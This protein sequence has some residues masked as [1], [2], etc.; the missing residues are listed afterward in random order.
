MTQS[1]T[2]PSTDRSPRDP[3]AAFAA[4][5]SPR[6]VA[7]IGA[8]ERAGSVGRTVFWN[9]IRN[10]FGGTVY[11]VNPQR[12]SVLGVRSYPS[13]ADLPEVPDLVVIVTPASSVPT[14]MSQCADL[15]VKAA[16][17]L[18]AG[19]RETGP[20]GVELERQTL[21]HARR[22]RM[23]VLGPNCLGLMN[24]HSGLNATFANSLA[25]PG[26]VAFI[27]QS[28]ALC[29]AVLDWSFKEHVGFSV[30]A[31]LG[32]MLDVGWGDL[33]DHLGED[34]NTKSIVIYM[35]SIGDARSFLSAAREVALRKPIIVIKAGRTD[36]AA[37]AAASHTGAMTGSDDVLDAAFK[38]V[39]VLRVDRISD[40]FY[41]AEVLSKQPRPKGPRLAIITNAGGPGVLA[42]DALVSSGGELAPVSE[43][44]LTQLNAILP[45]AWSHNNPI[46]LLGDA[47]AKRYLDAIEIVNRD[48]DSDGTLVILTPQDMTDPTATAKA[49]RDGLN[50]PD[51]PVLASWM[52]GPAVA[53][54][55]TILGRAGIPTFPY[56]DTAAKTFCAMW[57]YSYNLKG[58]YETPSITD[59]AHDPAP[60]H[61]VTAI[62]QQARKDNRTLLTEVESKEILAAYDLP[63][64]QTFV[65]TDAD[66]AVA[67]AEKIGYPVV[68]KLYSQTVTHKTDVGGVELNIRSE[69]GVRRAF[70]NIRTSVTAKVGAAAFDGVAVQRMISREGYEIIVGSSIDSQFGPVI[71]F[72]AGGQLVEIFR[73]SA[74]GLPPLNSTLA[75]RMM[76]Q[77]RIHEA[78]KGVRG[79]PPVD[80]VALERFLVRF[81]QLVLEHPRIK[82]IDINPLLASPELIIAL[83]ARVILHDASVPD[84]Q[85]PRP[86]IRPY[87]S[88]Y[89]TPCKLKDGSD[90]LIRPIRPED[91][92]LL[93]TFHSTL[94]E[95]T[96]Y[97]R[98]FHPMSL[99]T[100]VEHE[101]LS[102]I[103]FNDYD[104]ELAL[105]ALR[106]GPRGQEIVAVGRLIKLR[107]TTDAEFGLIVSD[108]CQRQ[109]L[110]SELLRQLLQVARD[111]KIDRVLADILPDNYE[112]ET[113]VKKLGFS[114]SRGSGVREAVIDLRQTPASV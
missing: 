17:V 111:E 82:S 26:S 4:L 67:L 91:E 96:V 36:A 101:R 100:R 70:D 28:G 109:G 19:F 72:G 95:R 16:I 25:K 79:R 64:V 34:P 73:D 89:V 20:A 27:S 104:R 32:S 47:D 51:R 75:R 11:P 24:P 12:P 18:S 41:M 97:F 40:L 69:Q 39:G 86:A 76:E 87:P 15:G 106:T 6:S 113:L 68:L 23:R 112:M 44:T 56:P 3:R 22:G 46:D 7:V 52:G 10:P 110:G 14:V 43:A 78:L 45:A 9:L 31:S 92:P 105:V 33:I 60:R 93:V 58:L 63:V 50:T 42:T 55:E 114:V 8:T 74:L 107:F 77:T 65:A 88:Q 59:D 80:A 2:K 57:R 49:I 30:F 29:T 54:G 90:I 85:L 5:L 98:Y 71:L 35:E 37:R 62:V 48:V 21:E 84:D 38:R 13:V 66:R 81:S 99:D 94:S 53:E 103:C 61:A 108:Q 102:R 1:P 83:D